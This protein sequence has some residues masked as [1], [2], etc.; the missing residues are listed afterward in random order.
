LSQAILIMTGRFVL[1][2]ISYKQNETGTSASGEAVEKI[3]VAVDC[4]V[5][6]GADKARRSSAVKSA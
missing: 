3:A 2:S 6:F 1:T 5:R 4:V